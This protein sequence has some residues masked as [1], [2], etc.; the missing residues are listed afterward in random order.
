MDKKSDSRG[1]S[2]RQFGKIAG[3]A[4]AGTM[5]PGYALRA[6]AAET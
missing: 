4:A 3:A 6:L 2:R 5:L 1:I